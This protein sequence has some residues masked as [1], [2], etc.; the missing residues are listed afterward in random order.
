MKSILAAAAVVCISSA[1]AADD[2]VVVKLDVSEAA[3]VLSILDRRVQAQ[4][5][6]EPEWLA[7]FSTLPWR[8][9]QARE[10]SMHRP[11]TE[12]D[13]RKFVFSGDLLSQRQELLR[14]LQLWKTSDMRSDA[15]SVLPYLPVEA[16][17]HV[18]VFPVIKPQ[19][20]SFVFKTGTDPAIFLYLNPKTSRPEFE[21]TVRH[22]MHHIGLA[23][24]D[25]LYEKKIA[26]LPPSAQKAA[27][28]M[29]AFGEGLAVLAARQEAPIYL[30]SNIASPTCNA[31]GSKGCATST[32]TSPP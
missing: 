4:P 7:L 11:F 14:T 2:R 22:E 28:W 10:T 32:A 23:S 13:F 15:L 6:N 31:T 19:R 30:L 17:I 3:Q 18:T 8:R 1:I 16:S 29:G 24:A 21:N 9:L 26:A 27:R 5:V 20:N 12:E 25:N